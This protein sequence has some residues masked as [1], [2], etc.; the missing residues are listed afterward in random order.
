MAAIL[1]FRC[2]AC[3]LRTRR[4][5][6]AATRAESLVRIRP[7]RPLALQRAVV[8][9]HGRTTAR[10]VPR[11]VVARHGRTTAKAVPKAGAARVGRAMAAARAGIATLSLNPR[12]GRVMAAKA[13]RATARV[14][15][16][17]AT[18]RV[19]IKKAT[20]RAG[21]RAEVEAE[22]EGPG[23]LVAKEARTREAREARTRE[24]RA[25][26]GEIYMIG[27]T[28][29][30]SYRLDVKGGQRLRGWCSKL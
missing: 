11:A 7:F 25:G 30:F 12:A 2:L 15:I 6:R 26:V 14:R 23:E 22:A 21:S 4:A 18:A 10:A 3:R 5:E 24:A 1:P 16:R 17:K 29:Q 19:R 28:S 8:A 13:S 27:G 9:K 20:A